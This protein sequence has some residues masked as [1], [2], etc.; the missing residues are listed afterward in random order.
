MNNVTRCFIFVNP[1]RLISD[2]L[3]AVIEQLQYFIAPIK[4]PVAV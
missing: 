2:V 3:S 4:A 1:K